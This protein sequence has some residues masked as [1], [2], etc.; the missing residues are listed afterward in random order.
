MRQDIKD[1]QK[2]ADVPRT[3]T[4]FPRHSDWVKGGAG[5]PLIAVVE[6]KDFK[7]ATDWV[8]SRQPPSYALP[9]PSVAAP[10]IAP[11]SPSSADV[12]PARSAEF[13]T[14]HGNL[15]MKKCTRCGAM[16][17]ETREH[18]GS[19]PSGNLKGYCRT[20]MNNYSR[21]YE[22]NNKEGRRQ[23]DEKRART[24]N[25]ARSSFSID[26]IPIPTA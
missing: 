6:A 25:N 17:P 18:F 11:P 1:G 8:N 22:E 19:T 10:S 7:A 15:Y 20:C 4:A 21:K 2:S 13:K 26:I 24:D 14:L 12:T 5:S 9:A 16:K 3:S 23:R